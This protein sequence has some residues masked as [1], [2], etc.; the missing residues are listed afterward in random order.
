MQY[1]LS[2][3]SER[4]VVFMQVLSSTNSWFFCQKGNYE[5]VMD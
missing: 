3:S 2:V 5:I 1:I 4:L